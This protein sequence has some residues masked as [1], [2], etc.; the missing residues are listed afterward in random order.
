MKSEDTAL[1]IVEADYEILPLDEEASLYDSFLAE[2]D[3]AAQ[4]YDDVD[5]FTAYL[6]SRTPSTRANQLTHLNN[7]CRFLE[8]ARQAKEQDTRWSLAPNRSPSLGWH[9]LPGPTQ[10]YSLAIAEGVSP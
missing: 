10:L 3:E 5:I 4:A 6:S 9:D 7:F 8:E 1:T 2:L